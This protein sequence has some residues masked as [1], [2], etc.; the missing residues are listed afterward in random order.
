MSRTVTTT[1]I[2][3]FALCAPL[4]AGEWMFRLRDAHVQLR[5]ALFAKN[6]DA[7][8][9]H[10]DRSTRQQ[11]G[12]L[13][14]RI[15]GEFD[16]LNEDQKQTLRDALGTQDDA[17][18]AAS[19][20]RDLLIAKFFL[21]AHPHLL[22]GEQADTRL[23][24]HGTRMAGPTGVV[25][26]KQT[27]DEV[28]VPYRFTT[29]G[30]FGGQAMDYRAQLAVPSLDHILG[31]APKQALLSNEEAARQAI[32]AFEQAQQALAQGDLE[33]FW[34]LLDCDSQSQASHF[35][36]QA[37]QRAANPQH[38]AEVLKLLSI[39]ADQLADLDGK[40]VWALSWSGEQLA[41]FTNATNPKFVPADQYDQKLV[42]I[43][44]GYKRRDR[45][46]P[47]PMV[48]FEADGRQWQIPARMNYRNG[49]AET[50]LF[51]RPPFYLRLRP[52]P[53]KE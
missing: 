6:A 25:V 1:A 30:H 53:A 5:Q 10:V 14:G 17:A 4:S 37:R 39:T 22:V 48:Q 16:L 41:Y 19:E 33:T 15:R 38:T 26:H 29:E 49:R 18:I 3:I 7:A 2:V 28:I 50:K 42:P 20:G 23:K 52:K 34:S 44:N 11:A 40:Q 21:D 35:A 32:T 46:N 31:P 36:D 45:A 51:L 47:E 43:P 27:P 12:L 24:D 8:W 9:Q 13:A